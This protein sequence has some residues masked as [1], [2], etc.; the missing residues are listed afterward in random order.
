MD[1]R[2]RE[3]LAALQR[4][5]RISN[6]ALSRQLGLWPSAMIGRVRRF[7]RSGAI[8]GYRAIVD[9]VALGIHVQALTAVKLREHSEQATREFEEAVKG[10][11]GVRACYHVTG[12]FDMVMM[13]A[14]RD[15]THLAQMIR[16]DLARIPGVIQ[17]E[18]MLI[19][20]ESVVDQGWP[21]V[22]EE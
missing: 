1:Q 14:L 16:V 17:F 5:G 18:T 9:P 11:V 15:L 12:Q 4:E 21:L 10:V 8:R 7:E 2:D 19:M 20:A 6:L 3:I 22:A 13:L